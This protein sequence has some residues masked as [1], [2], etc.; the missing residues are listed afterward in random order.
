[1]NKSAMYFTLIAPA[2]RAG[3]VVI[4]GFMID[5][6]DEPTF[7]RIAHVREDKSWGLTG[8]IRH[9][10]AH[11]MTTRPSTT[12]TGLTEIY[13]IGRDATLW[14]KLPKRDPIETIAPL[15]EP[16]MWLENLCLADDGIYVCGGQNQIYRYADD[17]WTPQDDGI[18]VPSVEGQ[19]TCT[20]FAITQLGDGSLLTV[21][22]AGFIAIRHPGQPW[23]VLD[24]PIDT[25]LR[26]VLP[27]ATG[28]WISGDSGTLLHLEDGTCTNHSDPDISTGSFDAL[29]W[30][31][32]HLYVTAGDKLLR[33]DDNHLTVVDVPLKPDSELHALCTSGDYLYA[34]G[35]EHVYRLGPD[36]WTYLLCPDNE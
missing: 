30:F 24:C 4:A 12:E 23:K 2:A 14:T 13:A 33:L 15:R 31:G 27:D 34:T 22:S 35:D 8:D 25:N 20:L 26:C 10:V 21:G 9:D 5:Q 6:G 17:Q 36:G 11:W 32:G 29:T 1:M 19:P 16:W 28:A 7:T 3:A 18:Y